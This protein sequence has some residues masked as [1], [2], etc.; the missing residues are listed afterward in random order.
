MVLPPGDL[1]LGAGDGGLY[2]ASH[3]LP[4]L[5]FPGLRRGPM[6]GGTEAGPTWVF[7]PA[8]RLTNSMTLEKTFSLEA[9]RPRLAMDASLYHSKPQFSHLK[10]GKNNDNLLIWPLDRSRKA[11]MYGISC[12]HKVKTHLILKWRMWCP[13]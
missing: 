11:S 6:I 4:Q 8:L 10:N 13:L 9:A 12:E 3:A 2:L 1:K 7:V 5:L